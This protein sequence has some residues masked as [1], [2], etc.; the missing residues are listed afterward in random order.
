MKSS[1]ING[2]QTNAEDWPHFP[3]PSLAFFVLTPH[4]SCNR[5]ESKC[6]FD[7]FLGPQL[8]YVH[9]PTK[10]IIQAGLKTI[11]SGIS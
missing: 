11:D 4:K 5:E 6:S 10:V 1:K 8:V 7:D 2:D 9:A 3:P